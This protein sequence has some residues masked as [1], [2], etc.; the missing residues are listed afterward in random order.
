MQM[1]YGTRTGV[2]RFMCTDN[3]QNN[4]DTSGTIVTLFI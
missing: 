4:T 2:F 1:K 3:Q